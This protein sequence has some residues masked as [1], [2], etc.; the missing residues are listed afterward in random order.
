MK[1][2]SELVNNLVCEMQG[3]DLNEVSLMF[4]T[5][6][7]NETDE[8]MRII[9]LEARIE[10]LRIFMSQ[11]HNPIHKPQFNIEIL[12]EEDDFP[13]SAKNR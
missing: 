12:D 2:K 5:L 1:N 8:E 13:W 6:L 11:L 7:E 3:I 4:K 10:V 9:I